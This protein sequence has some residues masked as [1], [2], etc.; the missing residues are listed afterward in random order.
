MLDRVSEGCREEKTEE[1]TE[2]R[3]E[4]MMGTVAVRVREG[5]TVIEADVSGRGRT[6]LVITKVDV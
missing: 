6:V 3:T 1:K 5:A 4:G 2:E